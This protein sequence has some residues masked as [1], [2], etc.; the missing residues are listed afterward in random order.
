MLNLIGIRAVDAIAPIGRGQSM[1]VTKALFS[2]SALYNTSHK[3]SFNKMQ[4]YG[5]K[6]SGKTS[7]AVDAIA[8]QQRVGWFT[9]F[10]FKYSYGVKI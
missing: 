5:A 9:Y 10:I 6:G 8:A 1:L 3:V 2:C 4:V 7:L